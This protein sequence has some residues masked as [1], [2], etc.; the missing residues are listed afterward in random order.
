MTENNIP[1]GQTSGK[2]QAVGI[3]LVATGIILS[4]TGTWW[5]P[6]VLLPGILLL[7]IGWF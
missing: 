1:I 5:G 7:I 6:A 2:F 3:V 4:V